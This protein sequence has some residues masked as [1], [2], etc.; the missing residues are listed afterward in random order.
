IMAQLLAGLPADE[1]EWTAENR[2]RWLLAQ[3]LEYHRRE[4]KSTWWEYFRLLQGHA[5]IDPGQGLFLAETWRLHPDVCA[6]TLELFYDGRLVSRPE[7]RNQRLNCVG[8]LEGTGLRYVPVT[9]T[10]NQ[11]DSP[12]EVE[13]VT[14]L[15]DGLLRDGATWTDKRGETRSLTLQDILI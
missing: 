6:F 13:R 8:P 1:A 10:G 14:E 15:V 3:T 7:N 12:E 4:D 9:H 5:T 2:A 11:N